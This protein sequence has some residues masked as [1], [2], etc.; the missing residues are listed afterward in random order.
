MKFNEDK[1]VKMGVAAKP[2]EP[3]Y[4]GVEVTHDGVPFVLPSVGGITYNVKVGDSAFGWE[5]DH[6]EPGISLGAFDDKKRKTKTLNHLACIGNDIRIITGNAKGAKGVVVGHHG[7]VEHVMA[8]FSSKDLKKINYGDQFM[9]EAWGMGLKI[10]EFPDA[11]FRN[12][13]PR[14][15][16]KIFRQSGKKLSIAVKTSVGAELMGSGLGSIDASSGDFDIQTSDP[17]SVKKYG[18]HSLKMGDI[19]CLND[20]THDFGWSYRQGTVTFGVIIH[21][22]SKLSGHGPG[23]ATFCSGP[24]TLF[25]IRQKSSANIG[26]YLKCGSYRS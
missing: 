12:L 25:D 14:L 11:I 24:I 5:G 15:A 21:G 1:L 10:K 23:V 22:D 6:I 17:E 16:Q 13:D 7:G 8:D 4:F 18:L 26:S 9:I 3:V 19:V 2:M 20:F